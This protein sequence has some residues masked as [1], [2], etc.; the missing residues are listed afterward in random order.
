MKRKPT[1]ILLGLF[2]FALAIDSCKAGKNCGCGNNLNYYN[3]KKG[4]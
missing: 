1:Y 3:P 2:L 4:R